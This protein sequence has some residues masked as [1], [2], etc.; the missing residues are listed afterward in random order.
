MANSDTSKTMEI[1]LVCLQDITQLASSIYEFKE[2]VTM[3]SENGTRHERKTLQL[4]L[5]TASEIWGFRTLSL[6]PSPIGP[7]RIIRNC[8]LTQSIVSKS[9]DQKAENDT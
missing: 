7:G 9:V 4:S 1:N 3:E 5:N 8:V 2:K 6:S